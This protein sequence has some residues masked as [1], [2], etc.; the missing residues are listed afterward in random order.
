[1]TDN[2]NDCRLIVRPLAFHPSCDKDYLNASGKVIL[3]PSVLQK[4][5]DISGNEVFTPI[6]F[7]M[8]QDEKELLSVGVEEFSAQEGYIYLP[9][10]VMETYWIPYDTEVVLRYIKPEKGTKISIQPHKTAFIDSKTKE[11]SFLEEYLKK[12]YPVLRAG[13]TILIKDDNEEYYINITQTTPNETISTL[14]TDLEV[15]FEKPLDYIEPPI[16]PPTP[17]PTPPPTNNVIENIPMPRGHFVP[18]AGK[19]YRLGS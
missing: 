9:S 6:S 17:P 11:K 8:I 10:F 3:P 12:Y 14:D 15:E 1:M 5:M 4:I 16:A 18:F 13:T 19:G 2:V 7:L